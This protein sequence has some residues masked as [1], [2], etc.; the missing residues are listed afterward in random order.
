MTRE[1]FFNSLNT[2][3]KWDVGVSIA[4][5]NPL[6][7]DANSIFES[8]D[9]LEAYITTNPLS[10]P[11]QIVSVLG[12]TEVAAYIILSV[13]AS[14]TYQKLAASSASGDIA[15]DV[16]TLQ[17]QVATINT[18]LVPA[19]D[20]TAGF[21]SAA[22]F[23]KLQ[24]IEAGAQ[25]NKIEAITVNGT[26][27]TITDKTA[28]ITDV[29]SASAVATLTGRVTTI[30]S[31]IPSDAGSEGNAQLATKSFVNST[32]QNMAARF[33]TPT[34]DG[35]SQW[36]SLTALNATDAT[37]Y[38]AG[39]STEPTAN[40]YAIFLKTVDGA[41]EQWRA[42]YQKPAD[43]AGTWVEQYK[44]GSAFTDAQTAA[45]NSGITSADVT[46]IETNKTDIATLTTTVNGMYTNTQIDTKISD[47]IS[48][49]NTK[50]DANEAAITS[51]TTDVTTLSTT[52]GDSTSGLVKDVA[53]QAS[54]IASLRT[55][56]DSKQTAAQVNALIANATIAG[57]NVNGAVAEASK[58]TNALTVGD[59][60]F[61]GSEA[62]TITAAD[63]GALTEITKATEDALGGIKIGYTQSTTNRAVVLDADGKAYVNVPA[64]MVY[65]AAA[66]GGLELADGAFSIKDGGVT[67]AKI[68]N[69]NISK[70]QQ[71][72][73][74][75]I[76]LDG[77]ISS[78]F[79]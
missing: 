21:L 1:E 52:V 39:E 19:S 57:G 59:K 48:P 66:N 10:F 43:G 32:V 42:S 29:A 22:D 17:Q 70:V 55:D 30:E 65:T 64:A 72:E 47:A 26:A 58:V 14:G 62:V 12:E 50:V 5:T 24:G 78:S 6:P 40:D 76:V 41:Q 45:L 49:V 67:D 44:V 27:V 34:A 3:A 75:F 15:Q 53:D 60:T 37:Y 36:A 56:V 13:G 28:T 25:A 63:L 20:T 8:I 74:D 31:K 35:S 79:S 73:G 7:L 61:D 71:T 77:G 54:L 16:A 23:T 9:A 11:G 33:I 46:Q 69:V 4:R 51:L 18:K 2:G 68:A 38:Y